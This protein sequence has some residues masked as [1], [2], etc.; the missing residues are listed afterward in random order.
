[1]KT[2]K[3]IGIMLSITFVQ[4]ACALLPAAQPVSDPAMQTQVVQILTAMVTEVPPTFE[5]TLEP[6]AHDLATSTPDA[7]QL[8][9]VTNT[10]APA[11]QEIGQLATSTLP[12]DQYA[13]TPGV[14]YIPPTLLPQVAQTSIPA[15]ASTPAAASTSAVTSTPYP[16]D[17]LTTLGS[18]TWKD[19]LDTGDNWPLGTDAFVNLEAFNGNLKMTGLVMQNG[20]R[21]TSQKAVNFYLETKAVMPACSGADHY[22]LIFRVPVLIEADQGYLFGI[23]CDGKY[24]L[25]K[26]DGDKMAVLKNWTEDASI[27]AGPNQVNRLGVMVTGQEIKMYINGKLVDTITDNSYSQ[28][29]FGLYIGPKS[30]QNLVVN[31]DEVTFYLM[32]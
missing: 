7:L 30:T 18:P 12:P 23:S 19:S 8:P 9:T 29:Y 24:A 2:I 4:A 16:G 17:P 28:G 25:R 21:L 31:F 32:P 11:E 20:W 22:G 14:T 5:P 1:M 26:W 3:I 6:A 13:I 15:G 10:V 27:L